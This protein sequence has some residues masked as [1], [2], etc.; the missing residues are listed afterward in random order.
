MS[1]AKPPDAGH[2]DSRRLHDKV[3]LAVF[4][5]A[6]LVFVG[7]VA[8]EYPEEIKEVYDPTPVISWPHDRI[9]QC[10]KNTKVFVGDCLAHIAKHL[11]EDHRCE[12]SGNQLTKKV[13]NEF[14]ESKKL[15][16]CLK[17][18]LEGK[19]LASKRRYV[20]NFISD[21]RAVPVSEGEK[22]RVTEWKET[23]EWLRF[24][25]PALVFTDDITCYPS[26]VMVDRYPELGLKEMVVLLECLKGLGMVPKDIIQDPA[27]WLN[28]HLIGQLFLATIVID[29]A[30]QDV[31]HAVVVMDHGRG[32]PMI[33]H[34]TIWGHE[35]SCGVVINCPPY[36]QRQKK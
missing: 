32:A 1:V 10:P 34:T 4:V 2:R 35:D 13:I 31:S 5:A 29:M 24:K 17:V 22:D 30:D 3:M 36:G 26:A 25:K 15:D 23:K 27:M 28:T 12:V 33:D 8:H 6:V 18:I 7:V 11:P 14:L 21:R 9:A 19:W 20:I 16:E